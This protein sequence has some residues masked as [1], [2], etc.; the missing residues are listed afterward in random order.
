MTKRNLIIAFL[1]ICIII[2]ILIIKNTKKSQ[3]IVINEN[4][5]NKKQVT[6]NF[7]EE[8]NLYYIRDEN[9]GEIIT[10]SYNEEDIEFYKEH[11]DY[12]PNPLAPRITNLNDYL[13]GSS[14]QEE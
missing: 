11:P 5:N 4:N 1:I 8:T 6:T 12:N 14:E 10:A 3:N 9:T 7:D 2:V 13:Y